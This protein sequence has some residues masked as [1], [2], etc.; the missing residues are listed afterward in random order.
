MHM[1]QEDGVG[2][3]HDRAGP[4][5]GFISA[6]TGRPLGGIHSGEEECR[7]DCRQTLPVGVSMHN[8]IVQWGRL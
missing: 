2:K 4:L 1:R 7:L 8:N 3:L 5:G 6:G